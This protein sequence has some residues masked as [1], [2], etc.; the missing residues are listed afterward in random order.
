MS[1]S[2]LVG[3]G[4][5]S[6]SL[7]AGASLAPPAAHGAQAASPAA[8]GLAPGVQLSVMTQNIFYGGDD[9]KLSTQGW[10]PVANGCPQALHR[11]A[12]IIAVS[13]ADVVGVQ[14]AENNTRRLARLLGWLASPRAHVV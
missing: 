10:C 1:V 4:L 7:A 3:S 11:L 12:H 2:R 13:G 14:E 6:L 8:P 5:V 9:Y